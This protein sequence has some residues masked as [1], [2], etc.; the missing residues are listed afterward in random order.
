MHYLAGQFY[1]ENYPEDY[2]LS[3]FLGVL[4]LE[5]NI[6]CFSGAGFQTP[7]IAVL[8]GGECI[9]LIS[10]GMPISS[11]LPHEVMN[12]Q[13]VSQEL[14][15]GTTV[16]FMTDGLAEQVQ[17]SVEYS[18]RL[19]R[20]FLANCHF[21]PEQIVNIINNDFEKF[22]GSLQGDDDIT[23]LIMQSLPEAKNLLLELKS[24]FQSIDEAI[25]KVEQFLERGAGLD[26]LPLREVL[27]NAIE[28]GNRFDPA[29]K[30]FLM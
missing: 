26:L 27:T 14:P 15:F 25:W 19:K 4:N 30:L 10:K 1:K 13:T 28:H 7:P 2:F 5:T 20:I 3:I 29:S 11:V 12:Y 24:T 16:L 22:N 6:C 17:K 18:H 23:F 8:P 21:N 9:Q